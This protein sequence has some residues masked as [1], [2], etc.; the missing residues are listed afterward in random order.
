MAK[1]GIGL[2]IIPQ[3]PWEAVEKE[4]GDY[5]RVY[6]EVNNAEA[7]API[8]AGWV[9]CDEDEGRA[10]EMAVRHIG[11][12]WH[13]VV[14]HYELKGTHLQAMKGYESYGAMQQ[15]VSAPGGVDAMVEFFLG[16]QIWGTPK[17]CVDKIVACT[18]RCG[19]ESFVSI[20]SYADMPYDYAERSMRL[21]ASEV[22]PALKAHRSQRLAAE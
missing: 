22:M 3:K 6:R 5:R 17:Q 1:L 7:P 8:N 15:M 12:Y 10:R 21:F 19:A 13:S 16:L 9:I 4:L 18:E 20:F 11:G 2:L 14:R